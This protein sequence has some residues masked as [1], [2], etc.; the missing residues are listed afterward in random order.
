MI[1]AVRLL[2]YARPHLRGVLALAGTISAAVAIDLLRPWPMKLVVDS[3]IGSQPLPPAAAFL[4]TPVDS[5]KLTLLLAL[6]AATVVIFLAGWAARLWQTRLETRLGNRMI[7]TLGEVVLD[8]L[9]RLPIG[10][11]HRHAT[12]DLVKRVLNDSSC[13]RDMSLGVVSPMLTSLFGLGSMFVIMWRL[14]SGLA[15]AALAVAPIL[16]V[17]LRIFSGPMERRTY[18]QYET[19]GRVMALSEQTLTALPIVRAF[20]REQHEDDRFSRLCRESDQ[21]YLGALAS[22]L[23]FKVAV[24]TILAL[25][26]ASLIALGGYHVTSGRLSIGELLVFMSYLASLYAPLE[27]LSRVSQ[28]FAA[29]TA[30]ARRVF[31][32][33][34]A[35]DGVT[36]IAD[37]RRLAGRARGRIQ[38][39][40][41]SF[42]YD[43]NRPVLDGIDLEAPAGATVALVGVTGAGKSTLVS[44]IARFFDPDR[45][46]VLL[47]GVDVRHLALDDLRAQIAMVLQEPFL[48]PMTVA[49]NIAY[50]R[51]TASREQIVAAA[52]AAHADDFIRALPAGYDTVIAERGST[53]SGGERQ[54]ISIARALL[55][56]A[57]I[58]ILD[59]PT[60]ALDAQT[61]SLIMRA[62]DRLIAGRTT[63]II[64]HRLSTVRRADRI[65]V[66]DRGKVV[67]MGTHEQLLALGGAYARLC[68][69]QTGGADQRLMEVRQ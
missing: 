9:Q 60:S 42:G 44:L 55:K 53:L 2:S 33:L 26:T 37:P 47:D 5:G 56:D 38:F 10:Y 15:V 52:A 67:E 57:P 31:E 62:L 18:Q 35:S 58:L 63:F 36:D 23:R 45:G 48:F 64:A 50:G 11:H 59:E 20:G 21:A 54:R 69:L 25:G 22:Q 30:G 16:G 40:G 6:T 28:T 68:R 7:Y 29:A 19:Q 4:S 46:R 24:D 12:G 3:V 43:A 17:S 41:V 66:L 1:V 14:D 39:E 8:R 65:A 61:E 34:D 49:E 51:P 13:I 32:V 27:T